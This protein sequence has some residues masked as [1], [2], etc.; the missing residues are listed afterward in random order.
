MSY[1]LVHEDWD[2]VV[3]NSLLLLGLG[4]GLEVAH[5]SGWVALLYILG[6]RTLKLDGVAQYVVFAHWMLCCPVG[7]VERRG[8]YLP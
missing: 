3:T 4:Y 7:Y 6:V 1:S 5:G 8:P 2:H